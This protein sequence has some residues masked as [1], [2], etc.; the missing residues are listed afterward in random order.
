MRMS[1]PRSLVPSEADLVARRMLPPR[2][3]GGSGEPG[4]ELGC[5]EDI[6]GSGPG[7]AVSGRLR[8]R[9]L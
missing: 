5:P 1:T 7:C 3:A 2:A 9:L 6:L 8:A 4:V